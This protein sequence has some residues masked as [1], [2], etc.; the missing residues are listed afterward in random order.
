MFSKIFLCS[1]LE[2]KFSLPVLREDERLTTVAA[3][4][5]IF[6]KQGFKGLNNKAVDHVA[7]EII[8]KSWLEKN[9]NN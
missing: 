6:Q 8:I 2:K 4:D 3:R 9:K 1:Q 7:A 5:E